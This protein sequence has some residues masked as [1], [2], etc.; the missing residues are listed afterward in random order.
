[1]ASVLGVRTIASVLAR[2]T[3][4]FTS[5][6]H[7][8]QVAVIQPSVSEIQNLS[9]DDRNLE[10]AVRHLHQDGLVVV[11]DV[12]P[13]EHLDILNTKMVQDALE[14]QARGDKGPFNYNR[15]NIQQDAP[16]VAQYFFP[17]IF[18]SK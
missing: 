7:A 5:A 4:S 10:K 11:E 6:R 1:M 13:H 2:G 3:R 16:P 14:L 15:G 12:I 17:S 8:A 18:T 9:L